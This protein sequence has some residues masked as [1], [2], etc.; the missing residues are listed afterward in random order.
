MG[1][2][3]K[4]LRGTLVG[5]GRKILWLA[6]IYRVALLLPAIV[7]VRRVDGCHCDF[8]RTVLPSQAG[9]SLKVKTIRLRKRCPYLEFFWSVFSRIRVSPYSFGMWENQDQK[10]SEYEHFLRNLNVHE[11]TVISIK[12]WKLIFLHNL[13]LTQF[14]ILVMPH[15]HSDIRTSDRRVNRILYEHHRYDSDT[16]IRRGL[17][18]LSNIKLWASW[19][20]S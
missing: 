18:T 19:E 2:A 15:L 16:V 10:N 14:Y 12:M 4:Y 11:N 8:D 13:F 7:V 17:R 5:N 9:R 3:L 6:V 1:L 20:N